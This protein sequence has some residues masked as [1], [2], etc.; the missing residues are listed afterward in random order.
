MDQTFTERDVDLQ[1]LD[2]GSAGEC[3]AERRTLTTVLS[4]LTS[5][6]CL[7]RLFLH[8]KDRNDERVLNFDDIVTR[9]HRQE[10]AA[11]D[12][13]KQTQFSA[14]VLQKGKDTENPQTHTGSCIRLVRSTRDEDFSKNKGLCLFMDIDGY[15][16][17]HLPL[18][19]VINF[20]DPS[21]LHPL[22]NLHRVTC[23]DHAVKVQGPD[24]LRFPR[25]KEGGGQWSFHRGRARW[26]Y[27]QRAVIRGQ[28]FCQGH[29]GSNYTF[30]AQAIFTLV[31][32]T[33][34]LDVD[35]RILTSM[36]KFDKC[37]IGEH[38]KMVQTIL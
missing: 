1:Y 26:R 5:A 7:T 27:R 10:T 31:P 33:S 8:H 15:P 11:L 28:R 13:S 4:Q 35:S 2:H 3:E 16:T 6:A 29:G 22:S 19:C 30:M 36:S 24:G 17:Y 12:A 21:P 38:H 34:K 20:R 32:S 18:S 14:T 37:P 9:A 23:V 25:L